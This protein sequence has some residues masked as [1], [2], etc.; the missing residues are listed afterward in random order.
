MFRE[1]RHE[2][3][4]WILLLAFFPTVGASLAAKGLK[5]QHI[6]RVRHRLSESL[7]Q[8]LHKSASALSI[9]ERGVVLRKG[10]RNQ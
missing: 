2:T 5:S 1:S 6:D 8:R 9:I 3:Q 10:V 4:I 7:K